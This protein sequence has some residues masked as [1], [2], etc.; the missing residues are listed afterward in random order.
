MWGTLIGV[1]IIG[2]LDNGMTL[3]N[4]QSYYQDIIQGFIIILAVFIDVTMNKK[5][6]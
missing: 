1:L 2:L 5:K 6:N 3:L 4:V